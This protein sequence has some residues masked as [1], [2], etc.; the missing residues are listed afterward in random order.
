M[1]VYVLADWNERQTAQLTQ[2]PPFYY[3]KQLRVR[4]I[5]TVI[6]KYHKSQLYSL[7]FPELVGGLDQRL[8]SYRK[9]PGRGACHPTIHYKPLGTFV[10]SMTTH[11]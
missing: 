9:E 4:V 7:A 1:S 6:Q 11:F 3:W 2:V 8:S 5:S 10:F